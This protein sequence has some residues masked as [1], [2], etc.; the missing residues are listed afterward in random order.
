MG[1]DEDN[2][3]LALAKAILNGESTAKEIKMNS[4]KRFGD[5]EWDA[6]EEY[7]R[8]RLNAF[9]HA[10]KIIP[11]VKSILEKKKDL[12]KEDP[13]DL[14]DEPIATPVPASQP[15]SMS[16]FGFDDDGEISNDKIVIYKRIKKGGKT[17]EQRIEVT[18]EE[19]DE[20]VGATE[21][22]PMQLSLF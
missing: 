18:R 11:V 17:V 19:I 15:I 14:F 4:I 22:A 9:K 10:E 7:Y 1:E 20:M 12:L 2:I 8:D 6:F 3:Q 21:S 13:F 5:R 16:L